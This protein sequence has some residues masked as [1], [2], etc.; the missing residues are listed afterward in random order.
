MHLHGLESL[1]SAECCRRGAE[2]KD[3]NHGERRVNPCS[4]PGSGGTHE[5][6]SENTNIGMSK[7]RH[8]PP[9]PWLHE[10]LHV[11][12]QHSVIDHCVPGRCNGP[13]HSG[14]TA[15]RGLLLA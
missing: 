2:C 1:L 5:A 13:Q 4:A 11:D 12:C 10:K 9:T 6:S 7:V 8:G 3:C 15:R 14:V